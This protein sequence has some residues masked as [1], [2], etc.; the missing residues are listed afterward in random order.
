MDFGQK[1]LLDFIHKGNQK[2]ITTHN[3]NCLVKNLFENPPVKYDNI[4][5]LVK[6]FQI[7]SKTKKDPDEHGMDISLV[8]R[9]YRS[10]DFYKLDDLLSETIFNTLNILHSPDK[11]QDFL[12][13]KQNIRFFFILLLWDKL[14][15]KENYVKVLLNFASMVTENQ[16]IKK[17]LE[18][19]AEALPK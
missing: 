15:L 8:F 11:L 17:T 14:F 6:K 19:W 16:K 4:Q 3:N 7:L 13:K 18:R 5:S 12:V 9:F 2:V 1:Q 10:V